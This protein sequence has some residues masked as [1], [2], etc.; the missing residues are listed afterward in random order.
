MYHLLAGLK[1]WLEL[2]FMVKLCFDGFSDLLAIQGIVHVSKPFRTP[3]CKFE[4]TWLCAEN[5]PRQ[6]YRPQA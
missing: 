3:V 4:K 6:R 1:G 5:G 2:E